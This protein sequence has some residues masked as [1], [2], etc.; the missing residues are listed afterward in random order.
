MFHSAIMLVLAGISALHDFHVSITYAELNPGTNNLEISMKVFSEDLEEALREDVDPDFELKASAR[1]AKMD[2]VIF[3]YISR[4]FSIYHRGQKLKI[5]SVGWELEQDI[6]F[7]YMQV[8]QMP[9]PKSLDVSNTLFFDRFDDQSNIVNVKVG[10][11]MES[12]FLE[13]DDPKKR[14]QFH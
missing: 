3:N 1:S 14:L 2:S 8:R 13:A 6:I 12:V 10:Q 4:H 5:E 9:V 11:Q 7:I